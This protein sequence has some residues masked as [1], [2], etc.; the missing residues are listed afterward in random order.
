[1]IQPLSVLSLSAGSYAQLTIN[2]QQFPHISSGQRHHAAAGRTDRDDQS[3][4]LEMEH[5]LCEIG[6]RKKVHKLG[7]E[8]VMRE[9][10]FGIH[11]EHRQ[12]TIIVQEG[13]HLRSEVVEERESLHDTKKLVL[14]KK[15]S[16]KY[17]IK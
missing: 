9:E 5:E 3:A 4:T 12:R 7:Q 17:K 15:A 6:N 13:P 16:K 11:K 8:L 1:M 14:G 2:S 10:T